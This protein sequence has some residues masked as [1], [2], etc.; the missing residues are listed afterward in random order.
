MCIYM[1]N[2]VKLWKCQSSLKNILHL[3][4]E[5]IKLNQDLSFQKDKDTYSSFLIKEDICI[6]DTLNV[7]GRFKKEDFKSRIN[8]DLRNNFIEII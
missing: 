1:L 2:I 8:I 7:F 3:K 6:I 5:F 4:K